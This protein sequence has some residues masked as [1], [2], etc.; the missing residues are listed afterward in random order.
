MSVTPF[1][2]GQWV[3]GDKFYGRSAL[4]DEIL[5]GPRNLLWLLGTRR[6]GKTS[7]LKQIE[8]LTVS[9]KL[10]YFPL[11]WDFQGASDPKELHLGFHDSLLDAGDGLKDLGIQLEQVEDADLFSSLN[12]VRRQLHLCNRRLLLLCDEVE[13]LIKLD[14]R[15]PSL[16]GKLRRALQSPEDIRSV[17]A[18]TIRLW[19][20]VDQ[21]TDTSPF[22]H[23][24][25][26]PLY[27]HN[28]SNEEALSLILQANLPDDV[29]PHF[30]DQM[31]QGIRTR[32]NNHPYLIQLLCKRC[33]ELGN[34]DEAIDQVAMD[35]MVSYFFSVDFTMLS[36][37]EQ[38]ILHLIA[39]Q[40]SST[41]NS[42]QKHIPM[43]S[44]ELGGNLQRLEHL[45]YIHRDAERRYVLANY[46]F[47]KWFCARR[48]APTF[49]KESLQLQL[50]ELANKDSTLSMES[51]PLLLDDRYELIERVGMGAQGVV[52]KAHDRL[53]R[54][55]V[56]IKVLRNEYAVSE[57]ALERVRREIL[58]ARD[59]AHK[60]VVRMYHLGLAGGKTYLIMQWIDGQTLSKLIAQRGPLPCAWAKK[61]AEGLAGAL[62]AAHALKVLH[63]D[64]KASN[65]LMDNAGEPHLSDFGLARLLEETGG[66]SHGIFIG[67]PD[68][69]SPEQANNQILD[70]RS[71][72]YSFGVVMFEMVTG[73]RPFVGRSMGEVLELHRHTAPPDPSA[74]RPEI[75]RPLSRLILSCLEKDPSRRPQRARDLWDALIKI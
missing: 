65:I 74:L 11:F 69:A 33:I 51:Q 67:T 37:S 23:G 62:E 59:I 41:S 18:S 44:S 61:I 7:L 50:A 16:L 5:D 64:I 38:A 8:H 2:V 10:G 12:K 35:P 58:L 9:G 32:C 22:L 60:N 72:L 19:A 1:V 28:L 57:E 73:K 29:R 42:I 43:E 45:G 47:R 56:A 75:P 17:L 24:F 26:P 6:I 4:I 39:D 25:T 63:R 20:L 21:R 68:Y 40:D 14:Q 55:T 49:Q 52:Y 46:F 53:L 70:E 66:T 13:E 27:I 15:D 48:E 34:L 31:A 3:R 71:D 30:N 36:K 54:S